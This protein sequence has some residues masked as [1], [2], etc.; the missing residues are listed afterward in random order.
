MTLR[1]EFRVG[2]RRHLDGSHRSKYAD[3]MAGQKKTAGSS[4][5]PY[6]E[7]RVNGASM[8]P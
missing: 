7:T 6:G 2:I 5:K 3:H 8:H 1:M 4:V